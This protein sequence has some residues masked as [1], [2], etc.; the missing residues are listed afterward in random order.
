MYHCLKHQ[1]KNVS[2][3]EKFIKD[4]IRKKIQS[5]YDK[6]NSKKMINEDTDISND[7]SGSL[8]DDKNILTDI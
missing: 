7:D 1:L 2:E 4:T 8:L 6:N 3:K 5:R